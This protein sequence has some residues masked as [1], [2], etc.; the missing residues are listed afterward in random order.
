MR[1]LKYSSYILAGILIILLIWNVQKQ[2]KEHLLQDD[3]VL[4]TLK[5]ILKPVHP[6]VKDLKLYKADKSYT[7]N[8]DKI[9]LCLHDENGEYYPLNHLIYVLLHEIAHRIND[10]DIGHTDYFYKLFNELLQKATDLNI[11]DPSIPII[12][13]YCNY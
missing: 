2:I 11:Y 9:F 8:K 6:I 3:P 5:E 13:N 1:I 4:Y 10:K 7:L 12:Q